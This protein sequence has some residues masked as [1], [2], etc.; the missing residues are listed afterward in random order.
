M[1][2]IGGVSR[3]S[4]LKEALSMASFYKMMNYYGLTGT[5]ISQKGALITLH[6][7]F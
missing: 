4:K 1:S 3:I 2:Q 6:F 5:H 7:Y